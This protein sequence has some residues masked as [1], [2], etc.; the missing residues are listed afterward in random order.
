[1]KTENYLKTQIVKK[2]INSLWDFPGGPVVKNCLAV[3]GT[4]V[5][6]LVWEDHTWGTAETR[7]HS[8]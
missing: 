4:Q 7:G 8:H 5:Q 3:Q 1:M 2:K 6:S